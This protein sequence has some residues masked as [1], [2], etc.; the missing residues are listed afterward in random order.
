MT[1]WLIL[2]GLFVLNLVLGVGAY[3]ALHVEKTANAQIGGGKAN[4]AEIA[5][6]VNNQT[7]VYLLNTDTGQLVSY[8]LDITGK[9][10]TPMAQ[11]N[12]AADMRR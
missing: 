5:G 7:V 1:K 4:V 8:R 12:V 11:R 9:R 10:F 2:S 3:Q 6:I